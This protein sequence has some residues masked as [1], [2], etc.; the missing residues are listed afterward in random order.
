MLLSRADYDNNWA[1]RGAWN[2]ERTLNESITS[3][4]N[5]IGAFV[6]NAIPGPF[7][8]LNDDSLGAQGGADT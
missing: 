5:E 7:K 3:R 8:H 2:R 6:C 1:G 4:P